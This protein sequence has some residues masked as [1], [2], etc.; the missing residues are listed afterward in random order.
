MQA[1]PAVEGMLLHAMLH[2]LEGD[3]NNARAWLTDVGR[4]GEDGHETKSGDEGQQNGRG[5]REQRAS[6]FKADTK[7]SGGTRE[8]KGRGVSLLQHVYGSMP[9][10]TATGD[11]ASRKPLHV[12]LDLIEATEIFR[13]QNKGSKEDLN[14]AMQHETQRLLDWCTGE[15]GKGRWEDAT[16]AWVRP[17]EKVR[18]IGEEMV[19]G[20]KGWREF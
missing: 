5:E 16:S 7:G 18:K 12:A 19:S 3:W 14:P 13:M 9:L 17:E 2:R 8:G 1:P 20:G 6:E 11:R 15:F 10:L 4:D